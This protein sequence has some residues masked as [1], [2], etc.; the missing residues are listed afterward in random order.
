M[1]KRIVTVYYGAGSLIR[2]IHDNVDNSFATILLL[3]QFD[4]CTKFNCGP[5]NAKAWRAL[6]VRRHLSSVLYFGIKINLCSV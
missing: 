2:L 1:D 5:N 3:F 4:L 6:F